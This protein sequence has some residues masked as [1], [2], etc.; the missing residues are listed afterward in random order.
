[1][2]R[3]RQSS[4]AAKV[5]VIWRSIFIASTKCRP[6]QLFP[7]DPPHITLFQVHIGAQRR[8]GEG[9]FAV[10]SWKWRKCG[11]LPRTSRAL[12]KETERKIHDSAA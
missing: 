9:A 11:A 10:L 4:C 6:D 12:I 7:L 1:M 8:A 2:E 3:Q 5:A